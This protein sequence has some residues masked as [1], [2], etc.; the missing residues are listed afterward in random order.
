M[1]NLFTP[2]RGPDESRKDYVARRKQ[3]KAVAKQMRNPMI[4]DP[5][6]RQRIA[7]GVRRARRKIVQVFGIRQYKIQKRKARLNHAGA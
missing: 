6:F 3:A 1:P 4:F 2:E 5:V 7:D